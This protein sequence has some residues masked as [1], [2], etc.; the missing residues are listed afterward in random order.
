MVHVH[1]AYA[2]PAPLIKGRAHAAAEW[3]DAQGRRELSL[4]QGHIVRTCLVPNYSQPSTMQG[5][6]LPYFNPYLEE[7]ASH[8]RAVRRPVPSRTSM[9]QR[10]AR[11]S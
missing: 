10:R 6:E 3:T 4:Q 11:M 5:L 8:L 2:S 9:L 7:S 1:L